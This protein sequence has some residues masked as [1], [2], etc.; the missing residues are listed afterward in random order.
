LVLA[1]SATIIHIKNIT[2]ALKEQLNLK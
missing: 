2:L 1:R